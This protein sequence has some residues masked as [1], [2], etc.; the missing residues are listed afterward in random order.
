MKIKAI[1]GSGQPDRAPGRFQQHEDQDAAEHDI[2]RGRVADAERQIVQ[3][4]QRDVQHRHHRADR[5]RPVQQRNAERPQQA[6]SRRLVIAALGERERPGRRGPARRTDGCRD[7]PSPTAG[8]S[9]PC[10]SGT[11]TARPA[12][13][14]RST[15][16]GSQRAE[17][18]L[19]VELLLEFLGLLGVEFQGG[20][21]QNRFC[22]RRVGH[23]HS[24]FLIVDLHEKR[25]LLPLRGERGSAEFRPDVLTEARPSR[26]RTSRRRDAA[27]CRC[28]WS[29]SA[30]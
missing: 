6:A 1:T 17:P 15:R 11:A 27:G 26:G 12:S 2:R 22:A 13:R 9:R 19:G 3:R 24:R 21:R 5:Q 16:G 14:R 10:S 18:D 29:R 28:P 7:G 4:D 30:R 25:P 20:F 23:R 8:R